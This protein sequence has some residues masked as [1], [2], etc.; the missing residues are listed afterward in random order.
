MEKLIIYSHPNC[1]LKFNGLN[2]PEKKE[3][4]ETVLESITNFCKAYWANY[5]AVLITSF[6]VFIIIFNSY[7]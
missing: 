4:L 1:L 5:K 7:I 6:I 2:H 3:R